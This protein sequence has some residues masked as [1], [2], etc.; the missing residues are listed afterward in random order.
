MEWQKDLKDPAAFLEGVKVDL[1]QDEVYVFTPQGEVRVFPRGS[2]PVDFAFA[3]HSQ[4][5]EHITGARVNGK[6]EP[7]R[8]KLRNGD[9][10][11]I[12]T[13]AHHQP[14]KDWLDIAITTR[15]RAKISTY[16][17]HEHRAKSRKRGRKT[18][19]RAFNK[20]SE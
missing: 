12:V 15:A 4:L 10:L 18:A 16:L 3:I 5:G 6:L 13:S 17:R 8:Y 7:L 2:T 9:V 11:E 1:F 19:A 14:S 20:P